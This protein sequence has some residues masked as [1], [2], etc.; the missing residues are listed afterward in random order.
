MQK[1]HIVADSDIIAISED[2]LTDVDGE[3]QYDA[4]P[5]DRVGSVGSKGN[6]PNLIGSGRETTLMMRR[7]STTPAGRTNSPIAV[8][9]NVD[10]MREH[11]KHIGP[12]NLA[13]RPKSTR[14]NT[15][16]IKRGTL[17]TGPDVLVRQSSITEA[18]YRDDPAPQG[19][20]GEGLL[21]PSGKDAKDGVQA[22][23]QGYGGTN[24]RISRDPGTQM[25][26]YSPFGNREPSPKKQSS[27]RRS[28]SED[29]ETKGSVRSKN[30]SPAPR[31]RN[32][33]RSGSIT[34]NI[35]DAGGVR[36]VV[37]ETNS[38]SEDPEADVKQEGAS[39]GFAE[40]KD[41]NNDAA[42]KAENVKR[43]RRRKRKGPAKD[44]DVATP[45]GGSN[46]H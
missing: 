41:R 3:G 37:L 32:I 40:D 21:K 31:K 30:S 36:K 35:I 8:R 18:P 33:A 39:S 10:N 14:Y 24:I 4:R 45:S 23:Q 13:S 42:A 44:G 28:N 15:V 19:G 20:E 22:V 9:G 16:K 26:A 46:G 25:D 12:S 6:G 7:R 5:R 29:S 1:S 38:S 43:K 11:L 34:E 27:T 2:H 17:G